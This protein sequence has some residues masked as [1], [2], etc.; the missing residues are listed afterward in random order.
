ML[1]CPHTRRKLMRPPH[2]GPTAGL[3]AFPASAKFTPPI[4]ACSGEEVFRFIPDREPAA[5]FTVGPDG[6]S[7]IFVSLDQDA[8]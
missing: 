1:G 6:V 5:P 4:P 8:P 7:P 3:V 2:F